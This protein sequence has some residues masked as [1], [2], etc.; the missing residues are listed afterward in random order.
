M[1]AEVSSDRLL[2]EQDEIVPSVSLPPVAIKA[3]K[4]A[5]VGAIAVVVKDVLED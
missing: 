4:A 3:L 1:S 2:T 5:L